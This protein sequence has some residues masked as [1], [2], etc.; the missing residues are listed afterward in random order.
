MGGFVVVF[1]CYTERKK[2]R[3]FANEINQTVFNQWAVRREKLAS[4]TILYNIYSFPGEFAFYNITL[5]I[6]FKEFCI[7]SLCFLSLDEQLTTP[8]FSKLVMFS[9]ASALDSSIAPTWPSKSTLK[10]TKNIGR[11]MKIKLIW[12]L[13]HMLSTRQWVCVSRFASGYQMARIKACWLPLSF[14]LYTL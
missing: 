6:L 14:V 1:V 11:K 3:N 7:S 9:L 5:A 8:V 4:W 10:N 12:K 2:N 13:H